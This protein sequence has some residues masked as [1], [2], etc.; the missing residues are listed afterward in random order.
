MKQVIILI[1]SFIAIPMIGQVSPS[2][3]LIRILS[4]NGFTRVEKRLFHKAV[5]HTGNID[6]TVDM[7]N[8][9]TSNGDKNLSD[10]D[11]KFI[12]KNLKELPEKES[13]KNESP[14]YTVPSI[15]EGKRY[16]T[17]TRHETQEFNPFAYI[18]D[19]AV[20]GYRNALWELYFR[21]RQAT[22]GLLKLPQKH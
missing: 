12:L 7:V 16:K 14:Y 6:F 2:V 10:R 22:Q 17:G 5:K 20:A 4:K 15:Y 8:Y 21:A 11:A 1:L 3:E 19:G 9:L 13:Y 18:E